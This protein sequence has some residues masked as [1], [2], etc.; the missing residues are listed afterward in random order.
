VVSS[1]SSQ[2]TPWSS[3]TADLPQDRVL[4]SYHDGVKAFAHLA[5]KTTD[6][7][8]P[9]PCA[10]WTLLE[11]SGHALCIA[12][13]FHRLLNAA[14]SGRPERDL[15]TGSALAEFNA[16]ELVA[17]GPM[18]GSERVIAFHAVA[19]RYGERLAE[20]DWSAPLGY[21]QGLGELTVGE[22]TLLATN[23]WHIH[24]WD[25]AR[26]FGWDYR[27]DDPE[28]PYAGLALR[29]PSAPPPP[30][31]PTEGP[32]RVTRPGVFAS[33]SGPLAHPVAFPGGTDPWRELLVDAGRRLDR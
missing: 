10:G 2:P 15:P 3:R 19:D 5:A 6:W 16:A 9:T 4:A 13:Y 23:E 28:V 30:A 17:L 1:A 8:V 27:P 33:G 21:W 22:H 12:R 29:G 18:P 11:L 25:V 20:V 31:E 24:A 7:A 14:S 26:S 32:V